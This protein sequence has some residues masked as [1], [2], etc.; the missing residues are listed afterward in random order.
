MKHSNRF[1]IPALI[2][3]MVTVIQ[4]STAEEGSP[5][6]LQSVPVW[7]ADHHLTITEP[8]DVLF[9]RLFLLD[10]TEDQS[11]MVYDHGSNHFLEF[12]KEGD[13]RGTISEQG[14]GPGEIENLSS[15]YVNRE[16]D[17]VVYDRGNM[18]FTTFTKSNGNWH[19]ENMQAID[20]NEV[21]FS[22]VL[23]GP[24]PD[25]YFAVTS[26]SF[27]PDN[28]S[29]E[30]RQQLIH[31]IDSSGEILQDS[32]AT[33]PFDN[34]LVNIG[35]NNSFSVRAIPQQ[36]GLTT[37]FAFAEQRYVISARTDEFRFEVFD[38]QTGERDVIEH[39]IPGVALSGDE[40]Q[41][42]LD[43]AGDNFRREMREKMPEF[44]P[45]LRQVL[46]DDQQRIWARF[47][48]DSDDENSANWII[49]N[50]D[51]SLEGSLH[52]PGHLNVRQIRNQKI[53]AISS[54]EDDAPAI[55]IFALSAE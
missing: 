30:N 12:S 27:R 35:D 10:V 51:G 45:V 33:G 8:D 31:L 17:I 29:D 5:N 34:F 37:H 44:R 11:I 47:T 55:E 13:F 7:S 24:E 38:H 3:S 15:F 53:Y 39:P 43:E 2:F 23:P 32:L 9:G 16:N 42:L 52:L 20:Q 50:L 36:M 26:V 54:P 6:P 14:S 48:P 28:V 21:H 25:T 1:L 46:T 4:C 41:E 22:R 18:R 19:A 49:L 40:Q